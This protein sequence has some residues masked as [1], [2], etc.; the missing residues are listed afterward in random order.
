M[1]V[2]VRKAM[3]ATLLATG[4]A[5]CDTTHPQA[6]NAKDIVDKEAA[7]AMPVKRQAGNWEALHYTMAFEATGVTGSMAEV[8]K[9]GQASIGQKDFGGPECLD[10]GTAAKDD[11]MARIGEAMHFGP[12]W[13]ITRATVSDRGKV[14]FAA[15]MDDEVQGRGEMT[16]T[17]VIT[18]TTTD[19]LVTTDAFEPPPGKGHIHTVMKQEN[20]RVGDCTASQ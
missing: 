13:T 14:D 2:T 5:A 7:H 18:P 1:M 9:A 10:A 17:G 19:L 8:V 3:F 16:I 20:T 6:S 15:S 12:E 11:L 4:V